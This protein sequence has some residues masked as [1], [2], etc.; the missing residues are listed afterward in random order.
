MRGDRVEHS[1]DSDH[2]RIERPHNETHKSE[3]L[4]FLNSEKLRLFRLMLNPLFDQI[5]KILNNFQGFW[6]KR[7][8]DF[9]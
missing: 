2:T 1:A 6:D 7:F 4:K 9:I 8:N 5:L 3:V